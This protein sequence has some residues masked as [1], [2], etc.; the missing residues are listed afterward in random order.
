MFSTIDNLA[1][2]VHESVFYLKYVHNNIS[3][4]IQ[5]NINNNIPIHLFGALQGRYIINNAH[6]IIYTYQHTDNKFKL[7]TYH[8]S[9]LQEVTSIGYAIRDTIHII[10]RNEVISHKVKKR[11]TR[12]L[13]EC[14]MILNYILQ[15]YYEVIITEIKNINILYPLIFQYNQNY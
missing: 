5:I 1:D 10:H 15:R 6:A 7:S 8:S 9:I 13:V 11:I 3:D 4:I 2:I 12:D 14:R